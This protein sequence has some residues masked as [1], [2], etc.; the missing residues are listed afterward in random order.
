MRPYVNVVLVFIVRRDTCRTPS[1]S[2]KVCTKW[3]Y[4]CTPPALFGPLDDD[5]AEHRPQQ[6]LLIY[7][8]VKNCNA[9]NMCKN[10]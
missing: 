2:L 6:I 1:S 7:V 10:S 4:D 5:D 8:H 9:A 3:A